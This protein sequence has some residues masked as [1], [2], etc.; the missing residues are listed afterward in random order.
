MVQKLGQCQSPFG[1][2][3]KKW[4]E[5]STAL[6]FDIKVKM[7]SVLL[8]A[9]ILILCLWLPSLLLGAEK[10]GND[11]RADNQHKREPPKQPGF[12]A[13][14]IE[15]D[16]NPV[17]VVDVTGKKIRAFIL[18]GQS[19]MVGRGERAEFDSIYIDQE[20]NER[21]LRLYPSGWGH[22]EVLVTGNG[23]EIS[24][25]HAM[26]RAWPGD[27]IGIIKIAIG[28]TGI[29][30]FVPSWHRAQA[31][32]DANTGP[33]YQEH[34]R[35]RIDFAKRLCPDIEFVGVLWK[36]GGFD[37]RSRKLAAGYTGHLSRII[38]ALRK[39]TGVMDLPLFV[40]TYIGKARFDEMFE[41]TK[42]TMVKTIRGRPA[43]YDVLK[44]LALAEDNISHA[45]VV[46]HGQ[47][48]TSS[49]RIHF[50][51]KGQTIL[52]KLF[53]H[54]VLTYYGN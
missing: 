48:P 35:P 51:T 52:G 25:A 45:K 28:N 11:D 10:P 44:A 30:G 31:G 12:F 13:L 5:V 27:T 7:K 39:D 41:E 8:V 53:A 18:I 33:I 19:N 6:L 3:P 42:K 47:L 14:G 9:V 49:D 43:M 50:N 22:L 34:I 23:P 15:K 17:R 4:D 38:N 24:F 54:S 2:W 29:R 37:M 1:C 36:Q 46:V 26:A 21:V 40:G 20:K 16:F 32:R